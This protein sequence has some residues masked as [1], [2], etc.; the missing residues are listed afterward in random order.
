MIANMTAL[1]AA[2]LAVP[3]LTGLQ[4]MKAPNAGQMPAACTL[5]HVEYL[6]ESG[7]VQMTDW[8]TYDCGAGLG[9]IKES[10][11]G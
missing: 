10:A 1:T 11:H 9:V 6:D 4:T 8:Q 2:L 3:V 7:K 5:Q